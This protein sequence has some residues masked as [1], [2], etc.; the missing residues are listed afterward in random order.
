MFGHGEAEAGGPVRYASETPPHEF[1]TAFRSGTGGHH[2]AVLADRIVTR[3]RHG[4]TDQLR[5]GD[6]VGISTFE[7]G[8]SQ[9]AYGVHVEQRGS[10]RDVG[11]HFED[12]AT[13]RAFLRAVARCLHPGIA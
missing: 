8:A 13:R 9:P 11:Y 5:V 2:V 4:G 10:P 7:A 12:D 6:I 3:Y 1:V